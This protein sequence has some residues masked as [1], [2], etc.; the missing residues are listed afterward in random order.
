MPSDSSPWA[1]P[2]AAP[3]GGDVQEARTLTRVEVAQ[4]GD[5]L[6]V[7]GFGARLAPEPCVQDLAELGGGSRAQ[8]ERQDVGVV[9]APRPVGS[10]GVA[11]EGRANARDLVRG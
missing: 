1:L 4:V 6:P 2:L 3:A 7:L 5:V 10:R 8:A 11:A 9:P